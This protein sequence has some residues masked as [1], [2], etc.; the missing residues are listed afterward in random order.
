LKKFDFAVTKGTDANTL[1]GVKADLADNYKIGFEHVLSDSS[2]LKLG[3]TNKDL[4]DIQ[5]VKVSLILESQSTATIW[6]KPPPSLQS[7]I[8]GGWGE[9]LKSR[10]TPP[11][12]KFSG[13]V[14]TGAHSPTPT[15]VKKPTPQL[16]SPK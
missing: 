13:C 5:Y 11:S 7:R 12:R 16:F 6:V 2:E 4:L 8:L 1:I 3:V 10:Q 15:V 9:K 14:G